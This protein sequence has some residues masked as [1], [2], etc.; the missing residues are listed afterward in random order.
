[1]NWVGPGNAEP[2]C[3]NISLKVGITKIMRTA[4]TPKATHNTMMGYVMAPL[5]L[6]FRTFILFH[7]HSKAVQYR[8]KHTADLTCCDEVYI[9][10]VKYL[11]V[12]AQ[13]ICKGAPS[14]NIPFNL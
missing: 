6:F 13:G 8:I 1:M 14:L 11:R 5:T 3:L 10:A 12:L 4:T 7:I 2:N 9:E